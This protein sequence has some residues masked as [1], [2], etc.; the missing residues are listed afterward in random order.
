MHDG[1]CIFKLQADPINVPTPPLADL[2]LNS[3]LKLT[4]MP[5]MTSN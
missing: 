3:N 5:K 4:P 1:Y 2:K